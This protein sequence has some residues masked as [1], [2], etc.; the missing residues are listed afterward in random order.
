MDRTKTPWLIVLFH[1]PWYNSNEHH[2]MEGETMRGQF[3]SWFVNAKV[4]IVF[5]SHVHIFTSVVCSNRL[6]LA[7]GFPFHLEFLGYE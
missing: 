5:S 4:D 1:S 6:K 7:V 3:E 2:Y